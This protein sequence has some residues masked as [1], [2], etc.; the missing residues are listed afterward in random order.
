MLFSA[1]QQNESAI[2]V[3]IYSLFWDFLPIEVTTRHWVESLSILYVLFCMSI[4][5]SQFNPLPQFP[6]L[7]VL[8]FVL[9]VCVSIFTCKSVPFF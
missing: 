1:V 2:H 6:S 5:I 3:H 9:Y 7:G 4:P 8:R